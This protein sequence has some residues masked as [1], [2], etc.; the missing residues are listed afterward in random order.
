MTSSRPTLRLAAY[1]DFRGFLTSLN[2]DQSSAADPGMANLATLALLDAFS[3][4]DPLPLSQAFGL[5]LE[6]RLVLE[7]HTYGLLLLRSAIDQPP[8]NAFG[9]IFGTGNL[10]QFERLPIPSWRADEYVSYL[11]STEQYSATAAWMNG[12][13]LDLA[14]PLALSHPPTR[15]L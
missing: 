7:T 11:R 5:C 15:R 12:R 2:L 4:E 14:S 6:K 3:E 10:D 1:T 13:L 8:V 9:Q